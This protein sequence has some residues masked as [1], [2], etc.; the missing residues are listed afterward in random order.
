ME[1]ELINTE[2]KKQF[3]SK[4][5]YADMAK[6]FMLMFVIQ[7][8]LVC[9]AV[10]S[11]ILIFAARSETVLIAFGCISFAVNIIYAIILFLLSKYDSE[12]GIAGLFYILETSFS[13]IKLFLPDNSTA[14][15]MSLLNAVFSFLYLLKFTNAMSSRFLPVDASLSDSW[16]TYRKVNIYIIATSIGCAALAFIPGINI[17]A[18]LVAILCALAA[19]GLLVWGLVLQYKSSEAMKA[20]ANKPDEPPADNASVTPLVTYENPVE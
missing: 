3:E 1:N 20:F 9:S 14:L 13:I 6:K 19:I 11:V 10:I 18:G 17:L 12:F 4:A 7:I 15:L 16:D 2:D 5:K 8:F